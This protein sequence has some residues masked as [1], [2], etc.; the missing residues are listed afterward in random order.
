MVGG[1]AAF[2]KVMVRVIENNVS[3][4][5]SEAKRVD[6][7]PSQALAGP[8]DRLCRYLH[9]HFKSALLSSYQWNNRIM[10]TYHSVVKLEVDIRVCLLIERMGRNNA[11]STVTAKRGL[12]Q[13]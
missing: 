1:K 8:D 13:H 7:Y 6:G 9:H 12:V 3:V 5:A 2:L 10:R 11:F 4:R